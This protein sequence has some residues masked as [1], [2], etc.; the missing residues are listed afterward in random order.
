MSAGIDSLIRFEGFLFSLSLHRKVGK[1][2]PLV[3]TVLD[4]DDILGTV[5]VPLAQIPSAAHRRRWMPLAIKNAPSNG[6]L[7]LDCWVVSFKKSASTWTS[8]FKSSFLPSSMAK[9][10]SKR[11]QSIERAS[12][13]IKGSH[14]QENLYTDQT[15]KPLDETSNESN[16]CRTDS[17]QISR[18]LPPPPP[19][20]NE[21][22]SPSSLKNAK[23]KL[24][25]N[26]KPRLTPTLGQIMSGSGPPEITVVTPR[27]GPASGGTRITIRGANLGS[28][29]DD[30]LSLSINGSDVRS[31]L[32]WHSSAK[33]TCTTKPW[34]GSGPVAMVT[35]SGG[36]GTSTIKFTFEEEKKGKN[37]LSL[38]RIPRCQGGY[39]T[40]SVTPRMYLL[41][42]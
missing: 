23:N 24:T 37:S 39:T 42:K 5:T 2:A 40:Y 1:A 11:R 26:F 31:N 29:K 35:K 17:G 16:L 22:P 41:L 21:M 9:D 36:R 8:A 32:E 6:D 38:L 30:I 13:S 33:V 4:K 7:C 27:Y 19:S 3:F 14:S 20:S 18:P 28:C 10:R 12:V 15:L 25:L 34:G